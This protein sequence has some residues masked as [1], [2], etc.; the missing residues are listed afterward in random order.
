MLYPSIFFKVVAALYINVTCQRL[1]MSYLILSIFFFYCTALDAKETNSWLDEVHTDVTDSINASANWFD[2]FFEHEEATQSA[3]A[4]ARV[5]LGYIPIEE[6]FNRFETKL[7]LRLKLPN[8]KNRWDIIVSDYDDA[9]ERGVADE[10]INDVKGDNNQNDQ[11]NLA[12]RFTHSASEN[13]YVSTRLGFAKGADIYLRTRYRRKFS[14]TTWLNYEVEPAIYY[15]IDNGWGSRFDLD[16]EFAKT[17]HGLFKQTNSWEYIQDD[18]YPEWRHSLLYYYQLGERSAVIS[19]LFSTGEIIQGYQLEN[20]GIFMR[21]RCQAL[22]N[23]IYFEV[24]P[25]IHYPTY[26]N[27]ERTFGVALRLEINFGDH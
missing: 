17:E 4:Y 9:N 8:L 10:A 27:N 25:F 7:R 24:E 3:K 19:G 1:P 15:Y 13:K 21:Y 16:F 12:I 18:K 22:R 6:E 26:R 23:W 2:G 14:P 11:L 5:R 20:Q